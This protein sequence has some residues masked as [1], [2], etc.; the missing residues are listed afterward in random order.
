MRP[1]SCSCQV[2]RAVKVGFEILKGGVRPQQIRRITVLIGWLA[3]LVGPR[4]QPR[5]RCSALHI[6]NADEQDG[7]VAGDR[8]LVPASPDPSPF[9]SRPEVT[10][11]RARV[12]RAVSREGTPLA[13]GASTS[14]VRG[15][16]P[17][18]PPTSCGAPRAEPP[19]RMLAL[20]SP[21]KRLSIGFQARLRSRSETDDK[22]KNPMPLIPEPLR[23]QL[24][25]N[26]RTNWQRPARIRKPS[27][28][29]PW[30]SFSIPAAQQ[31]G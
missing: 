12:M 2:H 4:S 29:S 16:I 5:K 10:L 24:L 11:P 15:G 6:T 3:G 21:R 1:Q 23:Q 9:G 26:G 25:E 8:A 20:R 7:R 22:R 27:I 28:S 14:Q 18:P 17:T 31:H 30:P 13:R 19:P